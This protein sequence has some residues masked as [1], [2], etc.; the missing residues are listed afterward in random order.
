MRIQRGSQP[1][2]GAWPS[3]AGSESLP[4]YKTC[5][6][7]PSMRTLA[8]HSTSLKYLPRL[9]AWRPTFSALAQPNAGS[10]ASYPTYCPPAPKN[11]YLPMGSNSQDMPIPQNQPA[12]STVHPLYLLIIACCFC[13]FSF[14]RFYL[15]TH[16]RHTERGKDIGQ[17]RSRLP[18][19]SPIWDSILGCRVMP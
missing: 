6:R 5:G 12:L 13:G 8:I 2:L 3:T 7:V 17:G 11:S 18:E 14:L 1:G 4:S 10:P 16:K 9:L 19:G 15:F